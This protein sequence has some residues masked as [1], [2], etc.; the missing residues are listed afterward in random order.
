MELG[1][2]AAIFHESELNFQILAEY[3]LL[4]PDIERNIY[5]STLKRY[6]STLFDQ[7]QPCGPRYIWPCAGQLPEV[8]LPSVQY[9]P[10]A[11]HSLLEYC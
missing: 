8:F 10:R 5:T 6:C 3:R 4:I 2:I 9:V 7:L 11:P 1:R